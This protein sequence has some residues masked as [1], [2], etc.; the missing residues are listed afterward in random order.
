MTVEE[1]VVSILSSAV[2][3]GTVVLYATLGEILCERAGVLNLGIEGI[4]LVGAFSA[5][6]FAL[7]FNNLLL[8]VLLAALLG[9]LMA[10]IHGFL[11]ISLRANQVV[12]GLALT[13][14]GTGI[15]SYFGKDLVGKT[16]SKSFDNIS[17]PILHNIPV[18]GEIFFNQNILVYFSYLLPFVLF[19]L[20]K[21]T[22]W[23]LAIRSSGEKPLAA[24][25]M[26]I[27]VTKVRYLCVFFGGVICGLSGAYLSL[28]YTPL[29]VNGMTSGR[30]WIAIALVIFA[31]W[32]PL[33]AFGG[34]YLFGGLEA[35]QLRMQAV[36]IH[37]SSNLLNTIPY[38]FTILILVIISIRGK[39][40]NLPESLGLPYFREERD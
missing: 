40:S 22:N 35:M 36:G 13:M 30:G 27:K 10:L 6:L 23:G 39:K 32:N 21:K 14:F 7:M 31:N 24:E 15:S 17:I 25:I 37:I 5:F 3:S 8:A 9:G 2:K 38:L 28:A 1:I 4:M 16:L 11:S 12:S 20:F 18:I 26:G 29:W 34:A 19:F 33:I